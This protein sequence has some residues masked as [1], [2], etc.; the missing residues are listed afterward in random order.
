MAFIP[1]M[2]KTAGLM[3]GSLRINRLILVFLQAQGKEK[4]ELFKMR[5]LYILLTEEMAQH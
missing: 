5:R 1:T 3:G 4:R 2:L